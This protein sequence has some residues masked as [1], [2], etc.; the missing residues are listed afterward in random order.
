MAIGI[1]GTF[2][3]EG[4][5]PLV[6]DVD[7]SVKLITKTTFDYT[8]AEGNVT[9]F[10]NLVHNF[11]RPEDSG[12]Y[13]IN[14]IGIRAAAGATVRFLLFEVTQ[15]EDNT[16]TM[17]QVSVL[18]DAVADGETKVAMLEFD[19]GYMIEQNHAAVVACAE[20]SVVQGITLPGLTTEGVLS[21][22]DAN[23]FGIQNGTEISAYFTDSETGVNAILPA[24]LIDYDL[25]N[26][27][28]LSEYANRG[29]GGA[30]GKSAYEVAVDNG[31]EGTEEEWLESLQGKP[32]ADGAPGAPGADGKT[33][34]K[35]EDY[36]TD[37][38]KQ[39]M[40]AAVL[41]A[42]PTAEGGSF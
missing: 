13:W 26:A 39:E 17:K 41:A 4:N 12:N 9:R 21:F 33:P 32:G 5:F 30:S 36:F 10:S 15:N 35:G 27:M 19:G 29:G 6:E 18:G 11:V 20:T 40:V 25:I 1:T 22:E 14:K 8:V 37:A 42:L 16:V 7:V 31:F 3:P 2:K 24:A 38:D 23:Y 34:V 28:T